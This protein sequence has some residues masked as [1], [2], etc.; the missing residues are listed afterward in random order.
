MPDL[1]DVSDLAQHHDGQPSLRI[2]CAPVELVDEPAPQ[3]EHRQADA[4]ARR[5]QPGCDE[6]EGSGGCLA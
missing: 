6:Q 4:G 1:G 3:A 5:D 2:T